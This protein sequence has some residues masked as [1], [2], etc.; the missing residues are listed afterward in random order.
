MRALRSRR[1][2]WIAG[3][4]AACALLVALAFVLSFQSSMKR[5]FERSLSREME[6]RLRAVQAALAA[7]TL[8]PEALDR[9]LR[10]IRLHGGPG[11]AISREELEEKLKAGFAESAARI[12]PE[13]LEHVLRATTSERIQ[14]A[15]IRLKDA[16]PTKVETQV[17]R[18]PK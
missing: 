12:T 17:I 2:R 4:T 15:M 3:V 14:E 13:S 8:P 1:G 11:S 16:P 9:L 6:E 7:Q 5:G 18:V 10:S